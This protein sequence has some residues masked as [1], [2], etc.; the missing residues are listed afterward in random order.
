MSGSLRWTRENGLLRLEGE[1]DQDFLVP[2][3]DAREEATQQVDTIDLSAVSRVDSA[4]VALLVHLIAHIRRQGRQVKL[5]GVSEK[6][7]TL[8]Q[9]YNLPPDLIP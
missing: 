1:L 2:L 6:M 9:L 3:W 7:N 4:G 8:V 5:V